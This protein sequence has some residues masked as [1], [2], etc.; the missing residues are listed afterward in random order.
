MVVAFIVVFSTS[1]S[2]DVKGLLGMFPRCDYI[3]RLLLGAKGIG[4]RSQRV[5]NTFK[6]KSGSGTSWSP[7]R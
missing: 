2:G 5:F 7:G 6:T 3:D 1:S 4:Q